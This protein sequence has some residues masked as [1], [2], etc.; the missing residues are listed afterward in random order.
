MCDKLTIKVADREYEKM[1]V[2]TNMDEALNILSY[3]TKLTIGDS[4]ELTDDTEAIVIDNA[5]SAGILTCVTPMIGERYEHGYNHFTV[6][7]NVVKCPT[8]GTAVDFEDVIRV[9]GPEI[10]RRLIEREAW[11]EAADMI[12]DLRSI[13]VDVS[14]FAGDLSTIYAG[15]QED[16]KDKKDASKRI[17]E[18]LDMLKR[19]N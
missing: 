12:D 15:I 5:C 3:R 4:V 8:H 18:L 6:P 11:Q 17:G 10:T 13:S 16:E 14:E 19:A 1:W 2:G 7:Y 9:E